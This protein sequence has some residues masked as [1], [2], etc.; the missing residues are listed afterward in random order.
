MVTNRFRKF[1]RDQLRKDGWRVNMVGS[2][3][4]GTMADNSVE[5]VPGYTV[6]QIHDI[7]HLSTP[8][9]PNIVLINA[10][11]NDCE[12]G[13]DIPNI[14]A[15]LGSLLDSLFTEIPGTTL[16]VS[17]LI[18]GTDPDVERYRAEANRQYR[19][20]ISDRRSRG[21]KVVLAE[22]DGVAGYFDTRVGSSGDYFD[23]THP[24]DKGYLKMAAIWRKALNT[25]ES[26]GKLTA[27][28]AAPGVDDSGSNTCD[29]QYGGDGLDDFVCIAPGGE[30]SV[31]INRGNFVFEYTGA[32]KYK[33]SEG[34]L[35][36]RIH[37]A[38][39]DGD[40]RFDYCAA[41]DNGDIQCWR[42]GG[43]YMGIVFTGKNMGDL[44]GVRFSDINGD[45]TWTNSRGCVKGIEGQ[46]DSI[47]ALTNTTT[48]SENSVEASS[49]QVTPRADAHTYKI[50][51]WRNEGIGGSKLKSDGDRY[52]NMRGRSNG[53]QDYVWIWS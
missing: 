15:R 39:V 44:N 2:K 16:I 14:G 32:G 29:K 46:G 33:S 13:I 49:R 17:T 19:A 7:S 24:N 42:N 1:L 28:A 4:E 26:E 9:K 38:D 41:R 34:Y 35:Q 37:L 22:M 25:A 36:A 47:P 10:G 6:D 23:E 52:C 51:V 43:R 12:N 11:V 53:R 45:W 5:A 48:A 50:N 8:F 20:L 18:P 40:G 30:L 31:A 3:S 27:P 21:Q